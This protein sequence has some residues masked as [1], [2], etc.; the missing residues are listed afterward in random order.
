MCLLQKWSQHS[1]IPQGT[2]KCLQIL[3]QNIVVLMTLPMHRVVSSCPVCIPCLSVHKLL[4]L[5]FCFP[6]IPSGHFPLQKP[7][8]ISY[9]FNKMSRHVRLTVRDFKFL[10]PPMFSGKQP[11][12][13]VIC[14]SHYCLLE[15][16][17]FWSPCIL[18][19]LIFSFSRSKLTSFKFQFKIILS[20]R[21]QGSPLL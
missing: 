5:K 1:F 7:E 17:H 13:Q 21:L 10:P 3:M 12:F 16:G 6:H 14:C 19:K 20:S 4:L 2:Q 18:I 15:Y 11:T 9:S 8:M